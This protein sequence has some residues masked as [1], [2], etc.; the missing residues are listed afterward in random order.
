MDKLEAFKTIAAEA[1]RGDLIFPTNVN[2]SLK[3]QQ[4]L[5]D[6]D[7]HL[8]AAARLVMAEPL[9]S[10]R[11]VAIANSVAYNRSGMEV[12]SV[13][14]AVMRLGFRTLRSLVAAVVVRQLSSKVS[15][16]V[17]QKM[18]SQLWEHTA[19]VAALAHVIARRVTHVDPET[20]MFAGIVHEVGGFYL[21]SR[22]AEFPGILDGD[23]EDW[24]EYGEKIIGRGVLKKL[25]VPDQVTEA[26]EA[27][28]YGFRAVPPV[29]L[30][31]TLMLANDLSPV[32]SPLHGSAGATTPQ[33]AS[34]IDFVVGDGTLSNILEESAEEVR[35][36]TAALMF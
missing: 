18:S 33:S 12:T 8:E 29:T 3:I 30:G 23:R 26:V 27:L 25:S 20:A 13:S 6:P 4:T 31:D 17:L 2:A 5:N 32:P 19:N 35:E 22:A 11:T 28:W 9:L 24:A 1:S 7:C 14:V 34:T 10:A 36:L 15:D 21:L 16:P